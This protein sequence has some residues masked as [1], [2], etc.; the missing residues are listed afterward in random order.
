MAERRNV[1][2]K[3]IDTSLIVKIVKRILKSGIWGFCPNMNRK[4]L[5]RL[6]DY[7]L[8]NNYIFMHLCS[9]VASFVY[10]SSHAFFSSI[11]YVFQ[12]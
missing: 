12:N 4:Y 3:G 10:P 5:D 11:L 1:V 6:S 8:L 7:H 2:G 9:H